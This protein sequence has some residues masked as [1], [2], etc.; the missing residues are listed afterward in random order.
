MRK[1]CVFC[2]SSI[3][4]NPEYPLAAVRLGE[5]VAA[6]RWEL[7][8]GG[9]N[10]G[11]MGV[12][13]DAC[14]AAGGTVIG[15]IPESLVGR[16]ISGRAIEHSGITRLEI[17]DSMHTRKAR[18]AELADGFVAL[19]GGIGTFEELFEI[20]TWAQLG[21][22]SKPI[23]LLNIANYYQPLQSLLDNAVQEGFLSA[24]HRSLLLMDT[25]P[26]VLLD[27][28]THY[29]PIPIPSWIRRPEEL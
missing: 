14:L 9:G 7:I 27:A 18:M 16:E 19:P 24:S 25:D 4:H 3:G 2:G 23:G 17:V 8:Y 29:E 10:I 13:A 20:L 11:L 22:H 6:R 21:F 15:V 5:E 12:V 1:L 26:K 28:F